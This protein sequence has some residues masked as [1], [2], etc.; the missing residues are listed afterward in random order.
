MI[1]PPDPWAII[2]RAASCVQTIT[3]Q[4]FT[5]TICVEVLLVDVH[6]AARPVHPGVV[7]DHVELPE[8]VDRRPDHGPHLRAV[9][10]VDADRFGDPAVRDDLV[11]D[12]LR[13]VRVE[14][15]DHELSRPRRR[16]PGT[17]RS[18]CRRLHR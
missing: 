1:L 16:S 18:R 14:V 6:E 9:G 3:P 2:C 7:E 10:H 15:G 17:R 4:V 5:R 11:R 13:C 12:R 8:G